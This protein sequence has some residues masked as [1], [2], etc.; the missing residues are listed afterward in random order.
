MPSQR[1]VIFLRRLPPCQEHQVRNFWPN[2][3]KE[4][5]SEPN[6]NLDSNPDQSWATEITWNRWLKR[7]GRR[8]KITIRYFHHRFCYHLRHSGWHCLVVDTRRR[9]KKILTVLTS[10]LGPS[11]RGCE[12]AEAREWTTRGSSR[13]M[14]MAVM[15][16]RLPDYIPGVL[17]DPNKCGRR[18]VISLSGR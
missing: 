7:L 9:T 12:A 5:H 3:H 14:K 11:S 17:D 8:L 6:P 2:F 4:V 18:K 1:S 16:R 15:P 10:Y 13:L